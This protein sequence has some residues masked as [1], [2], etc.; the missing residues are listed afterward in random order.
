MLRLCRDVR[1]IIYCNLGPHSMGIALLRQTCMVI[2]TEIENVSIR[3]SEGI[4]QP[5]FPRRISEIKLEGCSV[6]SIESVVGPIKTETIDIETWDL[7]FANAVASGKMSDIDQLL[8]ICAYPTSSIFSCFSSPFPPALLSCEAVTSCLD[9]FVS[10]TSNSDV[11]TIQKYYFKL[12]CEC[13]RISHFCSAIRQSLL[14]VIQA[15]VPFISRQLPFWQKRIQFIGRAIGVSGDVQ[16]FDLVDGIFDDQALKHAC[17]LQA[18]ASNHVALLQ[19][20]KPELNVFLEAFVKAVVRG[21]DAAIDYL[22]H[23]AMADSVILTCLEK[24]ANKGDATAFRRAISITSTPTPVRWYREYASTI[25]HANNMAVCISAALER[26]H[27]DADFF[28]SLFCTY[29]PTIF[30][31]LSDM[32]LGRER[33]WQKILNVAVKRFNPEQMASFL[34]VMLQRSQVFARDLYM[35]ALKSCLAQPVFVPALANPLEQALSEHLVLDPLSTSEGIEIARVAMSDEAFDWVIDRFNVVITPEVATKMVTFTGSQNISGCNAEYFE[36]HFEKL[37]FRCRALG[38]T[39]QNGTFINVDYLYLKAGILFDPPTNCSPR[40][41]QRLFETVFI[42]AKLPVLKSL[43]DS[44]DP[45][46][47]WTQVMYE[48]LRRMFAPDLTRNKSYGCLETGTNSESYLQCGRMRLYHHVCNLFGWTPVDFDN[49][50]YS[51]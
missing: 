35:D 37:L 5:A 14:K 16:I 44:A 22:K 10:L 21:N 24:A 8:Q 45:N 46:L 6:A 12:P 39:V 29:A 43:L 18:A 31:S 28:V 2:R 4:L 40:Y 23:V 15:I 3:S 34:Q 32:I 47:P 19:H 38:A 48:T 1:Q 49:L 27:Q 20:I 26:S 7:L 42:Y 13:A 36:Q 9:K 25:R 51:T 41:L 11:E 30:D 17:F 33:S 50:P